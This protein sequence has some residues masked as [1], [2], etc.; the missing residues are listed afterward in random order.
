MTDN[1]NKCTGLLR[2]VTVCL[3]LGCFAAK[4]STDCY[5]YL[6][7]LAAGCDFYRR[8][9]ETDD[10]TKLISREILGLYIRY[11]P[12]LIMAMLISFALKM[13][14]AEHFVADS[15]YCFL[16]L[17]FTCCAEWYFLPAFV[18]VLAS[19]PPL[20]RL[21]DGKEPPLFLTV[22]F[23]VLFSVF[24]YYSLPIIMSTR[25]FY[26][27]GASLLWNG[28]YTAA[29]LIPA[30]VV[31]CLLVSCGVL[32]KIEEKIK[33]PAWLEKGFGY[34]GNRWLS[35]WLIGSFLSDLLQKSIFASFP[36]AVMFV[37]LLAVST[38]CAGLLEAVERKL[39]A[40]LR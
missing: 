30:F 5:M 32:Q 34:L 23:L 10:L 37:L 11:W 1:T 6:F 20:L 17:R 18:L 28:L 2:G 15:I 19:A 38:L 26:E 21:A 14:R 35:V 22:L 24:T 12:V 36:A 9:R 40:K 27:L 7:L 3:M 39:L 4:V 33:I 25:L 29:K 31:G 13:P 8:S 16:G